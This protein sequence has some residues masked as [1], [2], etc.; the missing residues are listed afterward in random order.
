MA[1]QLM[2]EAQLEQRSTDVQLTNE[3]ML[4]LS[5]FTQ[6]KR[7]L[8]LDRF[9]GTVALRCYSQKEVIYRQGEPGWTAFYVLTTKDVE[10][11][12]ECQLSQTANKEEQQ[13]CREDIEY[14]RGRAEALR[15]LP[16]DH[17]W[18]TLARIYFAVPQKGEALS[19][20][21]P[22]RAQRQRLQGPVHNPAGESFYVP[23]RGPVTLSYESYR[24]DVYEGEIFGGMSCLYRV[25]RSATVVAK[26]E[27]YALEL[28]RNIFDQIQRDPARKAQS[29]ERYRKHVLG[30]H[31]RE[32]P[33]F[34]GISDEDY[35]RLA[36]NVELRSHD[37]G[38]IIFDEHERPDS[39]YV[40]RQGLV[41]VC[42]GASWL[43]HPLEISDWSALGQ[44]LFE[45]REDLQS[46]LGVLWQLLPSS[47]QQRLEHSPSDFAPDDV[48]KWNVCH[49][50]NTVIQTPDLRV[51]DAFRPLMEEQEF[52]Q[53]IAN[54]PE[55]P[56]RWTSSQLRRHNRLLL[57]RILGSV[58]KSRLQTAGP[59]RILDYCSQGAHFGEMGVILKEPRLVTALA[60]GHPN[61][62]G[63][64]EVVRIPAGLF[65]GIMKKYPEVRGIVDE[66]VRRRRANLKTRLVSVTREIEGSIQYSPRF[67][68]LGLIHGRALMLI[69]LDH[70][71]R[72]DECVQ[73][74]VKVHDDGNSRLFLEG[75]RLDHYLIPS[76]CRSCLDPV[77]LT[78]CPVGSI[79]FGDRREIIIEDWCIG[80]SACA[81]HCP[82]N[83]IQM[84]DLGIVAVQSRGWKWM[85]AQKVQDENWHQPGFRDKRWLEGTAPFLLTREFSDWVMQQ[86]MEDPFD[87]R[88]QTFYFRRELRLTRDQVQNNVQYRFEI[89]TRGDPGS[90][91]L[92]VNGIELNRTNRPRQ[93]RHEFLLPSGSKLELVE[94]MDGEHEWSIQ[95]PQ[96]SYRRL[97]DVLR[98]GKNVI[99]AC[100][101][102]PEK[103]HEILFQLRLDQVRKPTKLP[104]HLEEQVV[105]EVTEKM[106]THHAV[107]CDLCSSLPGQKP[108]CVQAC[109]HEAALRVNARKDLFT[110]S[111]QE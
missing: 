79:R 66:T 101:Q 31:L 78:G 26:Q 10:H 55:Q 53:S 50:L 9:P 5:L 74:C 28:L 104:D 105:D 64:I 51:I 37:P 52:E 77:C 76:T 19:I 11:V 33:I 75:P 35:Q 18:R 97:T 49:A 82:Y 103:F 102:A 54:L 85:P 3:Q 6:L 13:Q 63:R 15:Q 58:L 90:V 84:H 89:L 36:E 107:V 40:V 38:E 71:T 62:Y 45:G 87:V 1:L 16:E 34:R 95:A 88:A 14:L 69:D 98:V 44:V 20:V 56:E 42:Q 111:S 81:D 80:C 99:A 91:R 29:D 41:K 7:K 48:S 93:G 30:L 17:E 12:R 4:Q 59:E 57:E 68:E 108:A 8:N 32:L 21:A 24:A 47:W 94:S 106:V 25:P 23:E 43:I 67:E 27:F 46:P 70:C 60:Y 83:A 22:H 100:V 110:G 65:H 72:C 61:D 92:W 86:K 39:I 73:A 109:P 2:P 96:H